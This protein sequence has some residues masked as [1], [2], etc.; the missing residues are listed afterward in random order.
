MSSS[1]SRPVYFGDTVTCRLVITE[2]D[3]QRRARAK[4][5]YYNQHGELV[6]EA[7]LRGRLPS[8]D[9]ARGPLAASVPE[10]A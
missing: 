3:D 10:A 2:V 8:V 7:T 4:A 9:Q 1:F 6:Q 5:K